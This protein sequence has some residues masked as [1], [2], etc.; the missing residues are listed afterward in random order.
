MHYYYYYNTTFT[1]K[2]ITTIFIIQMSW[3]SHNI[4]Y[5]PGFQDRDVNSMFI[6]NVHVMD[7]I[8]MQ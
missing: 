3:I 5:S 2:Q 8:C 1:Y 6:E 4:C 7:N